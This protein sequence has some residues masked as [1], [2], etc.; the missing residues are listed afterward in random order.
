MIAVDTNIL[1]RLMIDD[2]SAAKQMDLAKILLKKARQVFVPQVVQVELV[3][4]LESAYGFDK[5]AVITVLKHLQQS[6]VFVLQQAS[7]FD[8]ALIHFENQPAD[9][10]DYLILSACLED[11]HRLFT[12]DRK[13]ARLQ[14]VNLLKE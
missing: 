10:S 11:K 1:V 8:A 9:F 14:L 5:A 13:F 4:V 12:F 3:W 2:P 6:V 7:Q